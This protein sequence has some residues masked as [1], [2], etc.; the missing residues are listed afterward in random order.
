MIGGEA[1]HQQVQSRAPSPS[2]VPTTTVAMRWAAF[3]QPL[4]R[5]TE[6]GRSVMFG[7]STAGS[8]R[9][10][11][12]PGIPSA[13][14]IIFQ[15]RGLFYCKCTT[16]AGCRSRWSM[17]RH[18]LSIKRVMRGDGHSLGIRAKLMQLL[19]WQPA[20]HH[21]TPLQRCGHRH[22][23][24]GLRADGPGFHAF[25]L[26]ARFPI[27]DGRDSLPERTARTCNEKRIRVLIDI[28]HL[29]V[30]IFVC[31]HTGG[32]GRRLSADGRRYSE[33]DNHLVRVLP[34]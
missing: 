18:V 34:A 22:I 26:L 32:G 3:A 12:N 20:P 23:S 27:Q 17:Y 4:D 8:C 1:V 10:L 25:L 21:P 31:S 13:F 9:E 15:H 30:S 24:R 2:H 19:D 33:S 11:E 29:C 16:G 7:A 14:S 5:V 28:L 6:V